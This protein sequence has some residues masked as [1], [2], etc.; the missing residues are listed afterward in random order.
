MARIET[1][2]AQQGLNPGST[3]NAQLTNPVADEMVNI[4]KQVTAVANTL[5]QRNEQ[6]ENF[7]VEND[8]RRLQ[9]ELGADMQAKA[10]E[11]QPDGT[12]FH[13]TFVG[14]TFKPKRDQFLATVP[15]RLKPK[16]EA[17]LSDDG[18]AD[19]TE[20]SIRA[21]TEE[22]N[23]NYVYQRDEIK[24]AADQTA[25]AIS[26]QPEAYDDLLGQVL[27]LIDASSLPTPEKDKLKRDWENT[28]QIAMLNQL[29][30]TDPQGVFRELGYDPRQ[31][32]PTTQFELVSRAVQW[33]ESADNPNAVS[34]KGAVG[35][36]QVMPATAREIAGKLGDAGFPS[37]ENDTA[38]AAYLTNPYVNKRYGEFYLKEQ[39]RTFANTRDPLEAALVAYNAGP[40]VAQ[41]WVESGY[42]DKVL[43]KETRD[44]KTNIMA[45]I[46][47]S[48]VKGD[49][50]SVKFV[51][52]GEG[53]SKDLQ[54][55][56]A[57]AFATVG[58]TKVK[59]NSGYRS[60]EKNAEVGGADKSQHLDGNAMDIDVSGMK[61]TERIEL[62][63]A[64][65]NSGVTGIGVYSNSIHADLGGRRAWGP[66]HH[67]TS[68]PKWAQP[69]LGQHLNG[70]TPPPRA[71]N[72]RYASLPYDTRQSFTSKAD[73]LVTS[74]AASAAKSSSVEKVEVKR[75][76]ENNLAL[77]RTTGQGDP[78]FN[79]TNV[80]TILGEDEYVTYMRKQDVAQQTFT[81]TSGIST[82]LPEDMEARF[83][84]YTPDPA[85]PDFAD[86]QAVQAA[87][88]KEVDR[89]TRL[90]ASHPDQAAL[91]FPEVKGVYTALQEQLVSGDAQPAQVQEFVAQML[92]TQGQLGIA[93]A[94][95]A[96][97]TSEWGMQIGRALSRV[98]EISGKNAAEVRNSVQVQY[99]ELQ[100]YFGDYTDE[101]VVYALSE[102]KGL[103]K[104]TADLINGYMKAISVGGDPFRKR[105]V[106][107]A[108]DNDQVEGFG[109][110]RIGF[111]GSL[112]DP[113]GVNAGA[114]EE[115]GLSPEEVLRQQNTTEE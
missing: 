24:L 97:V 111:G 108:I 75:S 58:Q 94:A 2:T 32:S 85:S 82:M 53:V 115:T 49:P 6:K 7:K 9:L 68:I 21:A 14:E 59:V 92:D 105:Q 41:K 81:A 18:G 51:G 62:I 43:P 113:F 40:S 77:L 84:E 55:R 36:M 109:N 80:A 67:D 90:R 12:G 13:D 86:Q 96:P 63:K 66:D 39:L 52:L 46:K 101:V 87:V 16:F 78:S 48:P 50:A 3:P 100:K 99:E 104:P 26:M 47:S 103:S 71:V 69:V 112:F 76:M 45:S 17:L 42:D 88:Q 22:R 65:S 91:E 1:Y 83:L 114:A 11:M 23:Q 30:E 33:Q 102:Y 98:P 73:Q 19:A 27:S 15:D 89:V 4:G 10:A 60:K 57:D 34:G 110:S 107:Q 95:R 35:L 38:V 72:Q 44:Y 20:W 8:Y 25:V 79:A 54:G 5:I 61:I 56:V 64:L 28:A 93:P 106:D 37:G 31:L 29:L 74:T 70:T